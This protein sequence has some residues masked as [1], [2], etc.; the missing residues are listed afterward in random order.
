MV[1]YL[2][3]SLIILGLAAG[4]NSVSQFDAANLAREP[5]K[6]SWLRGGTI[7]GHYPCEIQI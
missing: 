6:A 1:V 5:D 2:L 7:A 4:R 3:Y